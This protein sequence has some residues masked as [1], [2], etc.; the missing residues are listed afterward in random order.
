MI[1]IPHQ[2]INAIIENVIRNSIEENFQQ[3]GRWGNGALG[4][5]KTHWERSYRAKKQSG[6]TLQ[7]TGQLASSVQVKV[8][9]T[10]GITVDTRG[11]EIHVES[12]GGFFIALGSNKKVNGYSL[13]A[14]HQFG[15]KINHPGGTAF[16]VKKDGKL[17][18]ISNKKAAAIESKR[19]V[20]LN[21]TG[22]HVINIP[23]RPFLVVQDEDVVKIWEKYMEFIQ[24][25]I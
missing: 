23:K 18:F 24:K 2:K 20:K 5:G 21:R 12:T 17:R 8:N 7:D 13:A 25:N 22:P 4:G 16:F 14:I 3:E 11:N 19:G 10:G 1:K 6:K 15:A 9:S